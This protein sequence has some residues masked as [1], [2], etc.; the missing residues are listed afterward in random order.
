LGTQQHWPSR[1]AVNS[2]I[3]LLPTRQA[4]KDKEMV[5]FID[6][7]EA[8]ERVVAIE[9]GATKAFQASVRGLMS[10]NG[11]TVDPHYFKEA[12]IVTGIVT[13]NLTLLLEFLEDDLDPLDDDL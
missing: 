11:T 13:I 2:S 7:A 6:L 10:S 3:L 1:G 8:K 12:A 5:V 4:I 9:T